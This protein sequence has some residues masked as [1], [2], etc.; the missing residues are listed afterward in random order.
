[1]EERAKV[2]GSVGQRGNQLGSAAI[3][4]TLMVGLPRP[5]ASDNERRGRSM[6]AR[7]VRS[8]NL[9]RRTSVQ[10]KDRDSHRRALAA[11]ARP[12]GAE[13]DTRPHSSPGRS[14]IGSHGEDPD[15]A[16]GTHGGRSVQ[17]GSLR[18][19]LMAGDTRARASDER[20]GSR[21]S[22]ARTILVTREPSGKEVPRCVDRSVGG[23][24]GSAKCI[25]TTTSRRHGRTTGGKALQANR[26]AR[27]AVSSS[28]RKQ[29]RKL[30]QA[31]P[32]I[33]A[34]KKIPGSHGLIRSNNRTRFATPQGEKPFRGN[35]RV[36]HSLKWG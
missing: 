26:A 28:E 11:R 22:I 27:I 13:H 17:G 36:P 29:E 34:L 18:R 8:P 19:T 16:R 6:M 15:G 10:D 5:Q 2:S 1:M 23:I 35:R 4:R 30:V 20:M 9:G 25:N 33:P 31:R 3:R 7:A 14:R 21:T 12:W 24:A 32:A